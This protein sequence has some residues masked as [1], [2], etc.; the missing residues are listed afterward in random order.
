MA[1]TR[2]AGKVLLATSSAA[3]LAGLLAGCGGGETEKKPTVAPVLATASGA[4]SASS[5]SSPAV[6]S[7]SA[8]SATQPAANAGQSFADATIAEPPDGQ[9]LP[10]IT[11]TGKSVGKLYQTVAASWA[12]TPLVSQSGKKLAYTALVQTKLGVIE[13]ELWPEVA[14][15]HVRN[16]VALARAGYYDGLAF[17]RIIR[18]ERGAETGPFEMVE[19]GC[20][21]GTGAAEYGS[22]GYWLKPELTGHKA[23]EC[24]T[25][26]ALHEEQVE[27]AACKFYITLTKADWMD[28]R[29][30]LFG[31]V[32]SGLDVVRAIHQSRPRADD[33]DRPEDPIVMQTVSI[34]CR[35]Q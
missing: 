9:W 22:I 13:I 10:D 26:G 6:A 3:A 7:I 4:V 12:S 28:G 8:S 16:F 20:P 24:G 5:T 15:N 25:V 31:K 35:E 30:T 27:T 32:K 17:D 33:P 19:A 21:L 2:V 23:H 34:R 29:F 11:S 1:R 18:R 14:P